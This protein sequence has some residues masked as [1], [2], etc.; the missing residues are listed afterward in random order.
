[1]AS[2]APG[3]KSALKSVLEG[4]FP[5]PTLVSYGAPGQ[6]QPDEIVGVLNQRTAVSRPTMGT[7]RSREE[8]VETDVVF[9]IFAPGDETQQVVATE[10]AYAMG[11][12]LADHFRTKPNETLSGACREAWVSGHS[13]LEAR[14]V[15]PD[16]NTTVLG[17][18]AELTV[19]VTSYARV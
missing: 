14:V 11:E 18:T 16:D 9:S 13:L 5:A 6:Y 15:S 3:V 2:S 7:A 12:A 19:T 8:V 4:L 10:R 1:M 17:R